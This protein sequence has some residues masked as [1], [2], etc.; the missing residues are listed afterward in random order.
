MRKGVNPEKLKGEK[1]IQY[2]HRIIIPVYIPNIEEEYYRESLTVLDYCLNSVVQT[3]N[4]KTTAITLINNNSTSLIDEVIIKYKQHI[5]KY[6]LYN[7]NKGKVYA[8]YSEAIA[9]FEPY[10][11]IADADILFFSGWENAVFE[12]F[13][14]FKKA[15]V[16]A[17]VPSQSLAFNYNNSIF[18]NKYLLNQI[19]Y[20]KL[21]SDED[22][23][24]F[25]KGIGN[26]SSLNRDNREY[27][28]KE[29]QYFVKNNIVA[30]LGSGHYIATYRKEIFKNKQAFPIEKFVNGF[31]DSYFDKPADSFG[32]YRLSTAKA[33]A[34]HIGNRMD[35]FVKTTNFDEQLKVKSNLFLNLKSPGQSYIPY[36]VKS[37]FFRALKKYKKL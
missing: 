23:E 18:F 3:I 19:K 17:P 2:W 33:Y 34:Y 29:K 32:W 20:E 22:C 24:L 21:V 30:V 28:W 11:T 16:V 9:S 35:D 1:N 14:A 8:A 31:E 26:K 6:I 10:I 13:N 27:S 12:V 4:P 36:W 15:G 7:E 5:D 37:I 25:L